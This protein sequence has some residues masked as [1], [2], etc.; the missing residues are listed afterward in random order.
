MVGTNNMSNVETCDHDSF[1]EYCESLNSE[2]V[3]EIQDYESS[4]FIPLKYSGV[5]LPAGDS[6]AAIKAAGRL[7]RLIEG[8]DLTATV[9]LRRS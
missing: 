6:A 9:D 5:L 3:I 4:E 1:L 7:V 2:G 8:L